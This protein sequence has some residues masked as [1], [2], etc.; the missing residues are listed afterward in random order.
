GAGE[1]ARVREDAIG[2]GANVVAPRGGHRAEGGHHG[3]ARLPH[4][5]DGAVDF[6]GGRHHPARAVD[7]HDHGLHRRVLG[8]AQQLTYDVVAVEDDALDLDDRDAGPAGQRAVLEHGHEDPDRDDEDHEEQRGEART[9]EQAA[10]P[11]GHPRLV[12]VVEVV[13]LPEPLPPACGGASIIT[14]AASSLRLSPMRRS[15]GSTRITSSVSSSPTLTRSAGVAMGRFDICE[16]CR[17]PS[18]PGSSSTNAPKSV[19]R[20][21]LPVTREPIGYRWDTVSHGS[22]WI[23]LRPSEM[24]LLSRSTLRIWVSTGCPFLSSSEG[25]PMLRVQDMSEMCRRPSTPGSSSTNAPKSV[26]FRTFPCT[27]MPGLSRS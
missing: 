23:C 15:L 10:R 24:R 4:P 6:L 16:M 14:A 3:L 25:C 12:L 18:T 22:G 11:R 21:T 19:R 5:L 9:Q 27:R 8:V 13:V 26:R 17:S 2:R 7:P 1:R 20:T